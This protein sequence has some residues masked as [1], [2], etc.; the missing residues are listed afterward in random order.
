MPIEFKLADFGVSRDLSNK[1]HLSQRENVVYHR[2]TPRYMAPEQNVN[3]AVKDV[4]KV[5]V[6][7]LGVVMFKLLFK[8]FPFT[9]ESMHEEGR[10]PRFLEQFMDSERNIHRVRLSPECT[11]LLKRMLAYNQADRCSL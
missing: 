1:A 4:Y 7:S 11:E 2:G 5:E 6:F 8:A 9:M 3:K 10:N